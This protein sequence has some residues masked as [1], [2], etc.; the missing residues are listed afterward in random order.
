[1]EFTI[2]GDLKNKLKK[3]KLVMNHSKLIGNNIQ[4]NH[5]DNRIEDD[6]LRHHLDEDA[7]SNKSYGSHKNRPFIEKSHNNSRETLDGE[8][9]KDASKEDLE[10]EDLEEDGE[11]E[12]GPLDEDLVIDA[13]TED[14]LLED[15]P[16]DCFPDTWYKKF[17]FLAGD[18]D[19]PFWQGWAHLR[20][21]T[22]Q[23][24]E[25]KYFETAVITM[26][27]LSSLALVMVLPVVINMDSSAINH[28]Y[29]DCEETSAVNNSRKA[30][31]TTEI[32]IFKPFRLKE[33]AM[34]RN[35][36][37]VSGKVK[38]DD[39]ALE[40]VHLQ[41]R[42]ILQDILYYMD[43]IFTVIFFLEMLIKWL[44][45]GFKK[46]FTNAWCWLDFVIV[47]LSL[48]NLA[49]TWAGAADIPAFRSMRTLRAL[50]PL[51][52][53]SRWEG[54]RVSIQGGVEEGLERHESKNVSFTTK[55]VIITVYGVF[56]VVVN[57]LVQAIPSIFNVLLVCLIFWLIFAI[58]GV[59]LFAGKYFKCVD[60][61]LTTLSHEIIPDK[62]AC[63][64]E[65]Y[66]WLNSAMNFDHVGKA[67]LCLFQVATFKGWIQIMNDAIDSREIGK[68]P[69]RETNIYMYLYF[70]FFIIFGSFFTL[71][72]FIGVIIDN[73]NEQKKKISIPQV[74]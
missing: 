14:A 23:L 72:L 12:E 30:L 13:A 64:A 61:N 37:W 17:P 54:M 16:S 42:P 27:L 34:L 65:N 22:F 9:K 40:D 47:M 60:L 8:E 35:G 73:F 19:A 67:Y 3:G 36:P 26:I 68:Q 11:N 70:V 59:Q 2:H 50:R 49:A 48:I 31:Y 63:I 71:N 56:Q 44:A 38:T 39:S 58:M 29:N 25:N 62:N 41:Y 57:A 69:I 5:Q 7:L 18:N 51:R 32:Y 28:K 21:K 6:F 4:G 43:K 1:M 20:L 55:I 10:Q 52:A 46:Y 33:V 15:Y 66:T 45:L 74:I 53:V 24:I